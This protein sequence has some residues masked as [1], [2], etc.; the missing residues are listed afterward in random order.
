MLRGG[1]WASCRAQ[2]SAGSASW[3]GVLGAL[4]GR[5]AARRGRAAGGFCAARPPSSARGLAEERAGPARRQY[6]RRGRSP[7]GPGLDHGDRQ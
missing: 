1:K 3:P 6:P 4:A 2:G 5:G 7:R